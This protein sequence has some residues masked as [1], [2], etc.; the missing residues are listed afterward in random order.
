MLAGIAEL[1]LRCIVLAFAFTALGAASALALHFFMDFGATAGLL[2][3][4]FLTR[5]L[6]AWLF[7]M[8]LGCRGTL[9]RGGMGF[10]DLIGTQD[11]QEGPGIA[12]GGHVARLGLQKILCTCAVADAICMVDKG[13][14]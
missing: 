13:L 14:C 10:F 12:R 3:S 5:V 7:L 8:C 4:D 6:P 1:V 2:H 9:P 11:T